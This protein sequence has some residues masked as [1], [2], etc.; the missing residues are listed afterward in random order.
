MKY[1]AIVTDDSLYHHGIKGQKHGVRNAEW[2]PI[3][4]WKAHLRREDRLNNKVKK[5]EEKAEK[6]TR[7]ASNAEGKA[8][9]IK[10][11]T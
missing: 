11:E 4:A 7:K 8:Y 5:M 6:Y 10:K 1:Y 9:K 2:Y 3:S